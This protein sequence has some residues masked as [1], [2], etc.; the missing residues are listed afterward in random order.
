MG[1]WV[2]NGLGYGMFSLVCCKFKPE[3]SPRHYIILPLYFV[4]NIFFSK[5]SPTFG[6]SSVP[7]LGLLL[8]LENFVKCHEISKGLVPENSR[9]AAEEGKLSKKTSRA[10]RSDG[11]VSDFS[12]WSPGEL[13]FRAQDLF[14]GNS[15]SWLRTPCDCQVQDFVPY[16]GGLAWHLHG[17]PMVRYQFGLLG[18]GSPK[19]VRH[20]LTSSF[21]DWLGWF[22]SGYSGFHPPITRDEKNN[23]AWFFNTKE[24]IWIQK[25]I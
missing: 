6:S 14:W 11:F 9:L 8:G 21:N 19:R 10:C 20:W 7:W 15:M 18:R 25:R 24:R 4:F 12:I 22:S 3:T 2:S 1:A 17:L 5:R 23:H 13:L 16:D